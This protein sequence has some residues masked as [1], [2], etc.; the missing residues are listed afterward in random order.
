MF[1]LGIHF[2]E[3]LVAYGYRKAIVRGG[4]QITPE[5]EDY[6]ELQDRLCKATGVTPD[7]HTCF[8]NNEISIM[9]SDG[10]ITIAS[11]EALVEENW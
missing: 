8:R 3:G 2:K 4:V 11:P 7:N 9:F 1:E 6:K 10:N 5:W